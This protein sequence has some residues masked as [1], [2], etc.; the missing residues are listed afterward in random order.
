[1]ITEGWRDY[2]FPLFSI[3]EMFCS[4]PSSASSKSLTT[5]PFQ[6]EHVVYNHWKPLNPVRAAFSCK[7]WKSPRQYLK[8]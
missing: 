8:E 3:Y 1:M 7:R 6:K 5:E 4:T 2:C